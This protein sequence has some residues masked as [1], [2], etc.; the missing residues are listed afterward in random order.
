MTAGAMITSTND[1]DSR[2]GRAAGP[3]IVACDGTASDDLTFVASR[4][5]AS[6]L[7]TRVEVLGVCPPAADYVTGADLVDEVEAVD[8]VHRKT[9]AEDVR[10]FISAA[11]AGDIGWPV[12]ITVG[13]PS[14]TLA[15]E[16]RARDASLLV[17]GIGRHNP[18]DRLYGT[19][20]TLATV[21]ESEVPVLA[22]GKTFPPVTS[23]VV[24]IDFSAAS[25]RA[26]CYAARLLHG[27]GRLSL[28]HVRPQF[29]EV[30]G[31]WKRLDAEYSRQLPQ[32]FESL[33][34]SISVPAGTTVEALTL[35]G[36]PA[37]T[38]LAFAQQLDACL[39]AVGTQ[40]QTPAERAAVGSVATR[41]LRTARC[42][43]LAVPAEAAVRKP[44]G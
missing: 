29:T 42:T 27:R 11:A 8:E 30:S 43:V 21:R 4:A 12:H 41:V 7:E 18:L 20:V 9:M 23:V 35:R 19:E 10:R 2:N 15:D 40:R 13:A 16:A 32:L 33:Q 24:G 44:A 39:I 6:A 25:I 36:D 3:V 37:A 5:A 22:V 26:A 14:R 28:V 1:D 31:E 17:M 34:A 38:L